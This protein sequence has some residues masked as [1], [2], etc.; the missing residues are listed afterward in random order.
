MGKD[1]TKKMKKEKKKKSKS[2]AKE[3]VVAAAASDG[4]APMSEKKATKKLTKKLGRAPDAGEVQAYIAKMAKKEKKRKQEEGA[5]AGGAADEGENAPMKKKAKKDAPVAPKPPPSDGGLQKDF[6]V[7]HSTVTKM[8]QKD[9]DTFRD[10]SEITI[11]GTAGDIS[12]TNPIMDFDHC[13][14]PADLVKAACGTFEKPSPIQAQCWPI[15]LSGRDTI[16]IAETG[17]GKTVAFG[18]PGMVHVRARGPVAR[19][20]P[21]ML[22]IAPTRELAV[23]TADFCEATGKRCSPPMRAVCIY[24]GVPKHTQLAALN[25]G[26]HIVIA[27]PG[28][29]IDLM[30][31]GAIKLDQVSFL[32]LD[33]ADR[34]LDMGFEKEIKKVMASSRQDRQT[35]M[36]SA[37]WP[38][39][40]QDIGKGYMQNPIRVNVGEK[41]RLTSNHRVE[42]N[43][44]VIEPGD[45]DARLLQL[46]EKYHKG[47][48]E[49]MLIFGLYK[50]ET[51]RVATMLQRK[52]YDAKAING[53]L[54]QDRRT[55][56]LEDF[57]SG[58]LKCMV[59]TDVA[60]RGLDVKDLNYVINY[61]FPLTI[62][63][64]V[65]RIGRTGRAGAT[66][67]SCTFF[68][69]VDKAHAGSL[70]NIL[71][72]AG[73]EVPAALMNFGQGTKAKKHGTYGT[74]LTAT[75]EAMLGKKATRITF[76]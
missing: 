64:Y 21:F 9:I 32:V 20:K 50:K 16:G 33:E 66:G 12:R 70:G 36:F 55:Q 46:L 4:A 44:E 29:L 75:Q 71:R 62:E 3:E 5:G 56:V 18:L 25:A 43:V 24:G 68:T 51:E 31:Q 42:Q 8:P 26:V 6:Y 72:E 57:K 61:T 69:K 30:E 19:S 2:S 76:D 47:Q 1:G 37:T 22:V 48:K 52:G 58:K 74:T 7:E 23:Q 11:S 27:T 41:D 63:D 59:A 14:M 40:V 49:R 15:V 35:L 73:I 54:S 45:K 10:A 67:I 17:S 28:R 60:A 65:H 38:R 53:D 13:G 39:E 34:M